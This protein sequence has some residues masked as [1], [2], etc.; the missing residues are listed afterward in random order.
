MTS[1]TSIKIKLLFLLENNTNNVYSLNHKI[2]TKGDKIMHWIGLVEEPKGILTIQS[3][4]SEF[5]LALMELL[6]MLTKLKIINEEIMEVGRKIIFE[7]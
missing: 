5:Q 1:E 7:Y 4:S 2:T 3:N 6:K